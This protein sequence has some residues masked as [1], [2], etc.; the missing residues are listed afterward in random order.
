MF[1]PSHYTSL[2][3]MKHSYHWTSIRLAE[4]YF[5]CGIPSKEWE[6]LLDEFYEFGMMD[7]AI[8]DQFGVEWRFFK[9]DY[10]TWVKSG[11]AY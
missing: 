7:S 4:L 5:E 11:T 9:S 3:Q 1:K 6:I 8:I 10:A 2:E